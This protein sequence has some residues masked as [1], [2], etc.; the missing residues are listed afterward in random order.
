VLAL[1]DHLLHQA[2]KLFYKQAFHFYY[3]GREF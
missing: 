3:G 2:R 1:K